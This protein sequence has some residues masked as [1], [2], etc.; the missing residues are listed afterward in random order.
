MLR[1]PIYTSD[2]IGGASDVTWAYAYEHSRSQGEPGER[3][4]QAR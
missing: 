1:G 3:P 4:T 2:G